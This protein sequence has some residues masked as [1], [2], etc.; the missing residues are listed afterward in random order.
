M[1]EQFMA[2]GLVDRLEAACLAGS[3]LGVKKEVAGNTCTVAA[4]APDQARS[5]HACDKPAAIQQQQTTTQQHTF[6]GQ[7]YL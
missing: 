2:G 6:R 5:L 1:L 7:L 3:V 4:A